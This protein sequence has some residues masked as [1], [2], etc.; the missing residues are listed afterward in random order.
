[1]SYSN[2]VSPAHSR[3]L[4]HDDSSAAPHYHINHRTFSLL[5]W[6]VYTLSCLGS[7]LVLE[8]EEGGDEVAASSLIIVWLVGEE[9]C[10]YHSLGDS[11]CDH[12]TASQGVKSL[13]PLFVSTSWLAFWLSGLW[14][15]SIVFSLFPVIRLSQFPLWP[16]LSFRC[17]IEFYKSCSVICHPPITFRLGLEWN[18]YPT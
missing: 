3:Q 11:Q 10:N 15:I 6:F 14:K 13:R 1:M 7:S 18:L 12:V 8:V 9:P 2:L 16:N 5:M 4:L 17:P